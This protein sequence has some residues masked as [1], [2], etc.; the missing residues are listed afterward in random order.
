MLE[1][2]TEPKTRPILTHT[3]LRLTVRMESVYYLASNPQFI[4]QETTNSFLK[5]K[6]SAT[7]QSNYD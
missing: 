2:V 1:I 7:S 6:Y 3:H 4:S 5:G